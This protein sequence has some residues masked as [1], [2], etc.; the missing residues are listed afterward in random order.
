MPTRLRAALVLFRFALLLALAASSACLEPLAVDLP[1]STEAPPDAGPDAASPPT[2]GTLTVRDARGSMRI[3]SAVPRS[4]RLRLALTRALHAPALGI[5]LL[6]GAPDDALLAD[7]ATAPLRSDTLARAVPVD[8]VAHADALEITP[9]EALPPGAAY[10]LAVVGWLADAQGARALGV[11]RAFGL[12]VS[13]S[14]DDGA[15]RIASWPPEGAPAVGP[16]LPLL[17]TSFDGRVIGAADAIFLADEAGLPVPATTRDIPCEGLGWRGAHCVA[18]LPHAALLGGARYAL[19]AGEGLRDATGAAITPTRA[20]FTTSATPDATLPEP[21]A[22]I[23]CAPDEIALDGSCALVDD[24]SV[25]LRLRTAEAVRAS[26]SLAAAERHET[27]DLAPRGDVRLALRSLVP[28]AVHDAVLRLTDTAGLVVERAFEIATR[29]PLATVAITEIRAD[30]RGSEPR[31]EYVEVINFGPVPVDLQGFS[32]TDRADAPGDLVARSF[33]LPPG[34]RALLVAEGFDPEDDADDA[35][36]PGV[37][38][39]R[40]DG[41]LGSGG[42]ANGGEPLFLRDAE[43]QRISAAPALAAPAPGACLVR[44]SADPRDGAPN[45]FRP[46]ALGRC[47]PGLPDRPAPP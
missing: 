40:L 22:D 23:A 19:V 41:S 25:T 32:L 46:D 13:T 7:L 9:R 3:A 5:H 10:T 35:P 12:R 16:N 45:A 11:P 39:L 44:A 37:P 6:H 18:V 34:A 14:P 24:R 17:A 38:L 27:F 47:T 21:F 28:D 4:P 30:P 8:L 33:V 15:A 42:L 31:Q 2:V 26:L 36:A 20:W 43:G 29:P 1:T